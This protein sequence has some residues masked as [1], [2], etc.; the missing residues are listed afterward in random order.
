M[1]GCGSGNEKIT[2]PEK[3]AIR[4]RRTMDTKFLLFD[5]LFLFLLPE[6]Y[7]IENR[8]CCTGTILES[9]S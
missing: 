9:I 1:K 6:S 4:V 5:I 8:K 2:K 3:K 7:I